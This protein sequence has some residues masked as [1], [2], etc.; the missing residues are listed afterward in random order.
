MQAQHNNQRTYY[1]CRYAREYALAK[2]VAHPVNV[3]VREE[4]I[5]PALDSWLLKLFTPHRLASTIREMATSCS[6]PSESVPA[7]D[8]AATVAECDAKLARY[9]AAL[10]A[11]G[12]PA[13][14][15]SWTRTVTAERAAALARAAAQPARPSA[16]ITEEAIQHIVLAL[17]DIRDVIQNADAPSK[18]RI[19]GQLQL[20]LTYEPG[21]RL[22]HVQAALNP[23]ERGGMGSVR[24]GT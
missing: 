20:R 22:V 6:P 21:Q 1:R 15:A 8:T 11:G 24:G 12:D 16:A 17:G 5:L 14:I 18:A 9:Q 13:T 10:D 4:Q 2:H 7:S 23:H 3:Y 19:Y